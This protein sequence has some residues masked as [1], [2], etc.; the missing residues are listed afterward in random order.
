[1]KKFL[2][3]AF[4]ISLFQIF[5]I[6]VLGVTKYLMVETGLSGWLEVPF[7]VTFLLSWF[8]LIVAVGIQ[9]YI[10]NNCESFDSWD[11]RQSASKKH[12]LLVTFVKWGKIIPIILGWLIFVYMFAL[13]SF[14]FFLLLLAGIVIRNTIDFFFKKES[15]I[16]EEPRYYE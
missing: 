12:L 11:K 2:R 13:T 15:L 3:A 8:L 7:I 6:I 1:M 14:T 4:N 5:F 16:S 9:G 10:E